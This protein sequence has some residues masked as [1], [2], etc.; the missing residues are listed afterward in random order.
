MQLMADFSDEGFLQ[1]YTNPTFIW[2]ESSLAL[3]H[4]Q[5]HHLRFY[6]A[7]ESD[8]LSAFKKKSFKKKNQMLTND[9][10]CQKKKKRKWTK[11]AHTMRRYFI[12]NT[13]KIFPILAA[14]LAVFVPNSQLIYIPTNSRVFS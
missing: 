10:R 8:A 7:L 13:R 5:T 6:L 1:V 9:E 14:F 4:V 12:L 2:A 3:A 11:H